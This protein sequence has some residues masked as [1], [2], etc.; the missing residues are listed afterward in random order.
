MEM[1]VIEILKKW[2][3]DNGYDGLYNDEYDDICGCS[4]DD[5]VP[6]AGVNERCKAGYF[7]EDG[8]SICPQKEEE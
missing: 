3:K 8:K 5:F 6:C 1:N 4:L 7:S 2:L